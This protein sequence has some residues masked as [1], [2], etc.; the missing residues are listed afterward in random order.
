MTFGPFTRTSSFLPEGT[1]FSVQPATGRPMTPARG[2]GKCTCVASGAVSVAA[3]LVF[4]V[5]GR[6]VLG[7]FGIVLH[8]PRKTEI[9]NAGGR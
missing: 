5:M 2:I 3:L 4:I 9:Y 1:S 6:F 7:I 8:V